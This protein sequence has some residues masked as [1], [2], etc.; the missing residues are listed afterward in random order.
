MACSL[1]V[2]GGLKQLP[3]YPDNCLSNSDKT[4][5]SFTYCYADPGFRWSVAS[6]QGLGSD[7]RPSIPRH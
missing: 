5:R 6:G 3:A 2:S 4:R 7:Y 1:N